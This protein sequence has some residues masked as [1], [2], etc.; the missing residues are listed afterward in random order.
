MNGS[1]FDSTE[2]VISAPLNILSVVSP[3]LKA[4]DGGS[5][6]EKASTVHTCREASPHAIQNANAK[7]KDKITNTN[8]K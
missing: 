5:D 6:R 7:Y 3:E 4:D 8:Y 1:S 2:I